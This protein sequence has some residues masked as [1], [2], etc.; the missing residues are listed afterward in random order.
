MEL[1]NVM[2]TKQQN[3]LFD[4]LS[5]C[6]DFLIRKP[7]VDR[8]EALLNIPRGGC[9]LDLG[10]GTG[11]VSRYLANSVSVVV[12]G[13]V[14]G[15]MLTQAKRKRGLLPLQTDAA[16]LPF[17]AESVDAIL[18]VD[19]LHHFQARRR[20]AGEMM[21]VLKPSGRILIEE[22]DIRRAFIRLVSLAE[23]AV[24]C[25]SSFLTPHEIGAL[26]QSHRHR[27]YFEMGRFFTFRVVIEKR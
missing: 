11:R 27:R 19:A 8:L 25:H 9:L 2:T 17:A 3:R 15:S 13:D 20:I 22:Q 14:N 4:W 10:G 16:A 5:P 23:R 1:P 21:R 18:V 12:V 26:F 7:E 6:Y 24:G